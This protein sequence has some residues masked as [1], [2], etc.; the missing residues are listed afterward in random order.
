MLPTAALLYCADRNQQRSP[1]DR[2]LLLL[3][4]SG[5]RM[6]S[7]LGMGMALHATTAYFQNFVFW[8][9]LLVFYL[10]ALALEVYLILPGQRTIAR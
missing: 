10:Y 5:L 4:G 3:V 2:L 6:G 9:W 7:V 1:L 8:I